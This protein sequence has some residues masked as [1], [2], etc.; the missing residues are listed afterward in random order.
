MKKGTIGFWTWMLVLICT[1]CSSSSKEE[2]RQ[3]ITMSKEEAPNTK[4]Q[5]MQA[6][7]SDDN[8]ALG[9]KSYHSTV[10]REPDP[11]LTIVSN[12]E[13]ER[14]VDNRITLHIT[15]EGR[16]ILHRQF[17]KADFASIVGERFLKHARLE[18][19]VFDKTTPR[20]MSFAAS[21]GYPQSDLYVP[22]RLIV[23]PSGAILMEK[24]EL[25]DEVPEEPKE[26][27]NGKKK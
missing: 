17:T 22:I 27:G 26:E 12:E 1:G 23:S 4:P 21:V 13:G 15:C 8:I 6:T 3:L 7:V 25:M 9:G 5:S 14:F 20:G 16:T 19:L 11:S 24:D 2:K 10:R 18:G